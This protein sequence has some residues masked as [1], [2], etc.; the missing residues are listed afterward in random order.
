MLF[1]TRAKH[2]LA[3][4]VPGRACCRR[5]ELAG[6]LL[7]LGAGAE[8][9]GNTKP[10]DTAPAGAAPGSSPGPVAVS[11]ENAG[12]ARK[13]LQLLKRELGAT[14]RV[15]IRRRRRLRKAL[16]YAVDV[17]R[18]LLAA[19]WNGFDWPGMD[20]RA[21]CQRA[22]SRGAFLGAGFVSSPNRGYH[23]EV[24]L[25]TP[26]AA[27][28]LTATLAALGVPARRHPRRRATV[29]YLKDAE[30]IAA[31]LRLAGAH[32]ALLGFENVRAARAM[33]GQVNRL[34]N[35]ETANL[36]KVA[37]TGVRQAEELREIRDR[38]GLERLP[39][40][41]RAL[42]RLRLDHPEASYEELGRLLS[43]PVQKSA[44]SHRFRRLHQLAETLRRRPGH[45]S[46]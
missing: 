46:S 24:A 45:P 30:C 38:L 23:W 17:P 13:L 41:L 14:G 39:P 44:V 4:I 40:H 35:A 33:R 42:A 25:P 20:R 16:A 8:G 1:S 6:L 15:E 7:A 3:R 12:T 18:P 32:A 34:V 28:R 11:T 21:C 26:E 31:W 29:V 10:G 9:A 22:F 5:A 37:A 2:E 27:E 36:Q 19:F 43:P